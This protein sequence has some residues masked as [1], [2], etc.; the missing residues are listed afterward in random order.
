MHARQVRHALWSIAHTL[1]TGEHVHHV[2][3]AGHWAALSDREHA[4]RA[5]EH[6]VKYLRG[7]DDEPHLEHALARLVLAVEQN[8][9][10]R[11]RERWGEG[12]HD[13]PGTE[14]SGATPKT[15]S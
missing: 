15:P 8:A 11:I 4:L 2:G 12:G 14:T 6:L 5:A 10:A 7:D 13:A 3:D 1:K 9:R